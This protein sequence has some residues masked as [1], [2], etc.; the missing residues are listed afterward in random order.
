MPISLPPFADF[1]FLENSP[2]GLRLLT[3]AIGD[4]TREELQAQF[5]A[6]LQGRA[7]TAQEEAIRAFARWL[8]FHRTGPAIAETAAAT[9]RTLIRQGRLERHGSLIRRCG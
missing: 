6:S 5:L 9:I 3:R 1:R 2:E 8:G 7:W 4:Y